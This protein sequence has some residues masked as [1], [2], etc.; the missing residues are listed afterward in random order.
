MLLYPT[1][2]AL[3]LFTKSVLTL[4]PSLQGQDMA[5]PTDMNLGFSD[6]VL[7]VKH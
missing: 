4:P 7:Y 1:F 2:I 6:V 3:S 5:L